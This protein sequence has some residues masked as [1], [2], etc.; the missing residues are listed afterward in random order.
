MHATLHQ[1]DGVPGPQ[2]NSWVDEVLTAITAIATPVGALVARAIG[3][4]PGQL[5]AFW[6]DA[7]D[8]A[9]VA[10]GLA[11][12]SVSIGGARTYE[13]DTRN[14]GTPDV[15]SQY[16]QVMFFD[17]PRTP[18]WSAAYERA[19]A[20]R[21]YPAVRHLSGWAQHIGGSANDNGKVSITL[22]DSV[23]TLEAAGAAVMS[24]E[25][26]PS[27]DAAEL[28]GPDSFA[29]L[30]LLHADVPVGADR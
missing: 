12:G 4:G 24:T 1:I 19:G 2:D 23:E 9:T 27:E 26:L 5:V 30:P 14:L 8:A 22:A 28:T 10:G 21:L 25:L 11:A 29:I 6:T 3:P 18:Q 13:I 15:R 16:L 20:E 17:G 7:D